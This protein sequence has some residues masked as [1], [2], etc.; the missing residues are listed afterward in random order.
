MNLT[1]PY[2]Q[3]GWGSS[4]GSSPVPSIFGA[5][6]FS[7]T[8]SG[9]SLHQFQFTSLNPDVLNCTVIGPQ[10]KTYFRILDNTPSQ[11]FTLFQNRDGKS[12]AVVEWRR[13]PGTVVE[14]RDIIR[15]QLV[16]AW[17]PLSADRK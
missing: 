6:P 1:N 3:A 5:L 15:K 9:P 10:S 7:S 13:A 4:N 14:V 2:S 11:D 17:L 16:S 8:A 12:V